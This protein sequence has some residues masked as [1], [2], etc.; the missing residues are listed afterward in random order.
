MLRMEKRERERRDLFNGAEG[1]VEIDQRQP[2]T[3]CEGREVRDER[4][5]EDEVG[6]GG[7]MVTR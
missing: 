1:Q 3:L 6:K 7:K 4:V 5:R 2:F